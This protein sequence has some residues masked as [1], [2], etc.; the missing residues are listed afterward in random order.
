MTRRDGT[1][2]P[3]CENDVVSQTFSKIMDQSEKFELLPTLLRF[4]L[5]FISKDLSETHL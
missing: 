5:H 1:Q 4:L 2:V 3:R